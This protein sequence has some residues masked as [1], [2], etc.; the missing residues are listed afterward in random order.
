MAQ[1]MLQSSKSDLNKRTFIPPFRRLRK[2]KKLSYFKN[3]IIFEISYIKFCF[4][5]LYW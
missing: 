5:V 1:K 3:I 2:S 4:F